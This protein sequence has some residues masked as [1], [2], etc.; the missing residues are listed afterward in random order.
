MSTW[1][2]A[3]ASTLSREDLRGMSVKEIISYLKSWQPSP[4]SSEDFM[5]PQPSR[6]GLGHMLTNAIE[7]EPER[8]AQKALQYRVL[9]ATYV[10]AILAGFENA[11]RQKRSFP[12]LP[13]LDLCFWVIQRQVKSTN[14]KR[15]ASG[16]AKQWDPARKSITHLLSLGFESGSVEI[17][18]DLH[19]KVWEVLQPLTEDEDPTPDH[20]A[21]YGGSTMEPFTLAMNTIRGEAMEAVIR[22]ALWFRQHKEQEQQDI[23]HWLDEMPNVRDILNSHLDP[24]H[25]PSL[26]IRSVYGRMF[27][28]LVGLEFFMGN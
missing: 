12:L 8:F 7:E 22:Y 24:Q 2:G 13:V 28:Q 10:S 18:I 19:F 5:N 15:V 27:P 17:P 1:V 14:R 9:D 25:D 11:A 20:E 16:L 26:A 21:H 6:E 4:S 23:A 3:P